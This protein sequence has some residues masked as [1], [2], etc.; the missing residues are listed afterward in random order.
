MRYGHCANRITIVKNHTIFLE[1]LA[2]SFKGTVKPNFIQKLTVLPKADGIRV[3][4]PRY[5]WNFQKKLV[6]RGGQ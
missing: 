4:N 2:T 1:K 5:P 6:P 3:L